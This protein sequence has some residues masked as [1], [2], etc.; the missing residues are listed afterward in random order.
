M[1]GLQNLV[2]AILALECNCAT[3]DR[4]AQI[5]QELQQILPGTQIVERGPP[6]L[7]RAEARN[8]A[9]EV[10]VATRTQH[11]SFAAV[12]VPVIIVAS[13]LWIGCLT[14]LN[15]RHRAAEI[16]ILRAIGLGSRHVLAIF[17]G[18]ALLMGMLGSLLGY[19][20]GWWVGAE[21][22]KMSGAVAGSQD[23]FDPLTLVVA[24]LAAPVLSVVASWIPAVL[25]VRQDP[26]IVLQE[27]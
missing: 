5:R 16:G 1:L 17:L 18:K 15:V 8:K 4:V 24:L 20:S 21:L 9:A 26:A 10:A 23:L 3:P 13:G 7:A 22:A 27:A 14:L 12:L 6:A 2:N 19:A 11:E 25:A